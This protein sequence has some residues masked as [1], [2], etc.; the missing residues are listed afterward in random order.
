MILVDVDI[1]VLVTVVVVK[2]IGIVVVVCEEVNQPCCSQSKMKFVNRV[3]V[4]FLD[5]IDCIESSHYGLL[6]YLPRMWLLV[7]V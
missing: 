4:K 3:M 6:N 2:H 1:V 7:Y 5:C